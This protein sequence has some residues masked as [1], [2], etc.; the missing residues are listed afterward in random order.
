MPNRFIDHP[1][2]QKFTEGAI[3]FKNEG[4]FVSDIVDEEEINM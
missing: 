3:A 1:E 4:R 2:I